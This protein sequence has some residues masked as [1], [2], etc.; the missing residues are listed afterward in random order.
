MATEQAMTLVGGESSAEKINFMP[1]EVK[2]LIK[3]P[4]PS[5]NST[6]NGVE[7]NCSTYAGLS[8]QGQKLDCM[9]QSPRMTI[10]NPSPSHGCKKWKRRACALGSPASPKT[11]VCKRDAPNAQTASPEDQQMK[12]QRFNEVSDNVE[13]LPKFSTELAAVDR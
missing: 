11:L 5:N 12:Q 7:K 3:H 2:S 8:L 4:R 10:P 1:N 6:K 9:M 13:V